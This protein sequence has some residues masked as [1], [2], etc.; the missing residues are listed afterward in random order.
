MNLQASGLRISGISNISPDEQTPELAEL[1]NTHT[2]AC[3]SVHA[4][5][6]EQTNEQEPNMNETFVVAQN[7]TA[8]AAMSGVTTR[9]NNPS[10]SVIRQLISMLNLSA[11]EVPK[12]Y[13]KKLYEDR[14]N[15][16]GKKL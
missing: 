8:T 14:T 2:D 5:R 15:L 1:Q 4:E 12:S 11:I 16:T 7:P 13:E 3:P 6:V 9:K 10:R